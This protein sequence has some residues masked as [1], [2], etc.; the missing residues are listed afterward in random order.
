MERWVDKVALVTGASSGIGRC[1]AEELVKQGMKVVGLARRV[2][3]V[4]T[5][6]DELQ[7]KSLPGKLYPLQCNLGNQEEITHAI[8]W[9]EKNLGCVDLLVNN[10]AIATETLFLDG[11][12]DEWQKTFDVNVIG[13]TSITKEV[14][15]MMQKKGIEFSGQIIN[16][17]DTWGHKVPTNLK[18]PTFAPYIASKF[19]LCAIT[20]S[21]RLELAQLESNIKVTSLSPGLVETEMTTQTLKENPR[22]ALKPTDVVNAVVFILQTP[23]TVLVQEMII[24]PI[25]EII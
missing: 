21:L 3:M 1:I 9:I 10:A 5:L 2:D 19:A 6:A 7:L 20:E 16:V 12:M 17:N 22:L 23:E 4:T 24:T 18:R 13:L 14:L 25:R 15:T 8:K 11:G